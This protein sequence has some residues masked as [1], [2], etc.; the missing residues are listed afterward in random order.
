MLQFCAGY[1]PIL[2]GCVS[3][4]AVLSPITFRSSLFG[5]RNRGRSRGRGGAGSDPIP[6]H[7][8]PSVL[9]GSTRH[10]PQ[11]TESTFLGYGTM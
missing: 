3:Y 9:I 10:G 1:E 11:S 6:N 2:S 4:C 8:E 7:I 5:R